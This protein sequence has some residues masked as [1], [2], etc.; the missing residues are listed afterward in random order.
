MVFLDDLY[1]LIDYVCKEVFAFK[2]VVPSVNTYVE[3]GITVEG[4]IGVMAFVEGIVEQIIVEGTF[5]T[6]GTRRSSV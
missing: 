3:L 1:R 2:S 4:I 6:T 5:G